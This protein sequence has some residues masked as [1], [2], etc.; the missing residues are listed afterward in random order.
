MPRSPDVA[1]R[2]REAA[3]PTMC[4]AQSQP[5]ESI[6]V[7]CIDT[8]RHGLQRGFKAQRSYINH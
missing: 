5:R 7:R 1:V 8:T 6:S 2:C 4:L 3:D